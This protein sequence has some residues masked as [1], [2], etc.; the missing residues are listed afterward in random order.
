M[1]N[2]WKGNAIP[3]EVIMRAVKEHS[4]MNQAAA[5]L[6][7]AYQTF[8]KYAILYNLWLPQSENEKGKRNSPRKLHWTGKNLLGIKKHN[9]L[10][11]TLIKEGLKEQRC[12]HCGYNH[13]RDSDMLSPLI[14]WFNNQD[15][16]DHSASNVSFY[17]Y[18]CYFILWDVKFKPTKKHLSASKKNTMHDNRF[19]KQLDKKMET[20]AAIDENAERLGKNLSAIFTKRR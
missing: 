11:L 13:W 16:N 3:K 20:I 9:E 12:D 5:S 2:P 14:V 7:V 4:S 10:A 17:C 15:E 1:G 18:N 19:T 6:H 8:R